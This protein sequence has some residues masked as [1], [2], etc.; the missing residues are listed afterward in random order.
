MIQP[1]TIQMNYERTVVAKH[2]RGYWE[3]FYILHGTLWSVPAPLPFSTY[4]EVV[5]FIY[6]EYKFDTLQSASLWEEVTNGSVLNRQ[7]YRVSHGLIIPSHEFEKELSQFRLKEMLELAEKP[8]DGQE[9]ACAELASRF[10]KYWKALPALWKAIDTY[11]LNELFPIHGD[12]SGRLLHA[13]KKLLVPGTRTG[14]KSLYIDIVEA[15]A[16][17][18]AWLA[19]NAPTNKP[20]MCLCGVTDSCSICAPN[21]HKP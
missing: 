9:D 11:R 8:T 6:S 21:G 19:D 1:N 17:L 20:A 13:R 15:H 5:R 14:G 4:N 18:G 2:P 16:T 10:P 7:F 12:D 3:I